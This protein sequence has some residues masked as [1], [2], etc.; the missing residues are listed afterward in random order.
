MNVFK[1]MGTISSGEIV[2]N[3]YRVNDLKNIVV[4]TTP[5]GMIKSIDVIDHETSRLYHYETVGIIYL[6]QVSCEVE[7]DAEDYFALDA[8]AL[9]FF[10]EYF[11]ALHY[12][13]I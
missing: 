12:E 10:S 1:K 13:T 6:D 4:K 5:A 2:K 11:K 3:L 9:N 8:D 7:D